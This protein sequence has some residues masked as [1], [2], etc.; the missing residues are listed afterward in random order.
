MT[1][2]TPS[3]S[4]PDFGS[5]SKSESPHVPVLTLDREGTIQDSNEPARRALE[6]S[7]ED[8]IDPCFFSHVHGR[9]LQR[10]MRDLAHMVS[11]RKQRARWLLRLRTGNG[12]WRW[13]RAVARNHLDHSSATIQVHLRPL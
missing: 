2:P 11:H 13:Y 9:N 8:S 10:V 12:R 7:S 1:T 5:A 6:Y 4:I 3:V